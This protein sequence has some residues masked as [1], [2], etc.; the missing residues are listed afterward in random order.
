MTTFKDSEGREWS[1][2]FSVA[3]IKSTFEKTGVDLASLAGD[4][5]K[6]L[7]ELLE[8]PLKFADVLW[9][10]CEKQAEKQGISSDEFFDSLSGESI[11]ECVEP[12]VEAISD[13][14]RAPQK[15]A[16]MKLVSKLTQVHNALAGK[17]SAE[18]DQIDPEE[19]AEKLIG[20]V[21]SLQES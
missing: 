7:G 3:T 8:S 15:Q 18:L 16:L 19:V 11:V 9:C 2:R 21:S 14:S 4:Q 20:S 10:I 13:F 12:F 5:L 1:L 6:P 17:A